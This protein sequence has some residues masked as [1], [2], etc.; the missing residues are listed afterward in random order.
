MD[1]LPNCH[2]ITSSLARAA[3]LCP[4][5][6]G[7]ASMRDTTSPKKSDLI[8]VAADR[9]KPEP[10]CDLFTLQRFDQELAVRL[11]AELSVAT[12]ITLRDYGHGWRGPETVDVLRHLLAS[13]L[14]E[15]RCRDFKAATTV[16]RVIAELP[17]AVAA[18]IARNEAIGGAAA[19]TQRH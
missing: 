11:L 5:T 12:T 16:E 4:M 19:P 9:S 3:C 2:R 18:A 8:I 6:E 13:A 10:D 1:G 7:L 14:A 15:W 17:A